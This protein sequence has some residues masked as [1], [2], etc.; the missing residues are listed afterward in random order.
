[1]EEKYGGDTFDESGAKHSLDDLKAGC[2]DG[3]DPTK[4]ETY[5]S[6][7]DFNAIFGMD[8]DEFKNLSSWK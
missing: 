5:L 6:D 2:P 4:K 8:F 3:V 1:M 7:E